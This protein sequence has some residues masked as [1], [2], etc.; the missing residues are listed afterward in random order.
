MTISEKCE[1]A[2]VMTLS[3]LADEDITKGVLS[4]D[5]SVKKQVCKQIDNLLKEHD[6]PFDKA[7]P[8]MVKDFNEVGY[9]NNMDSAVLFCIY[10][11]F[12]NNK[13]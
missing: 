7:F 2:R 1:I 12:K 6:L 8:L 3:T 13:H 11:D 10:M 9:K 4:I 5:I